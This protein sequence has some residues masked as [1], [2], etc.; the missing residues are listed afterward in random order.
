MITNM[1]KEFTNL[2]TE[3]VLQ[4]T[5]LFQEYFVEKIAL[6]LERFVPVYFIAN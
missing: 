4:G 6:K 1:Q 2:K 5:V 3:N